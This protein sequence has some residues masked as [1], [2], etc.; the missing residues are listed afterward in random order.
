[1]STLLMIGLAASAAILIIGSIV[2]FSMR[3]SDRKQLRNARGIAE[4]APAL[5]NEWVGV[6]GSGGNDCGAADGGGSCD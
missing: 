5:G 1:M 3:L 2:T 4:G 6:K